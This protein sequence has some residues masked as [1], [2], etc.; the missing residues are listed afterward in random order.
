MTEGAPTRPKWCD[1]LA[2]ALLVVVVTVAER[3]DSARATLDFFGDE[4][5]KGSLAGSWYG[6][7]VVGAIVGCW[8]GCAF[9]RTAKQLA[10]D[11]EAKARL[12]VLGLLI[13]V[14]V[15]A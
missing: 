13:G 10:R 12:P 14:D 4:V 2:L 1:G 15:A 9:M 3:F 8:A 11:D 5:K 7:T 6:L